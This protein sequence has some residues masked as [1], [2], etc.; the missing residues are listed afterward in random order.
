MRL[1]EMSWGEWE[2][3]RLD[4]LR[5][6]LG[7]NMRANEALGLDF[8]PPGGES[9]R[10]VFERVKGFLA[11]VAATG[12]PTL[13]VTHRGVIR[14]IFAHATGWDM[15]GRPPV[16]LDWNAIHVFKLRADGT[17]AVDHINFKLPLKARGE[18]MP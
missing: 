16:K 6:E 2:G 12:E 14:S 8:T 18:T 13:A 15:L 5:V 17:P 9:P 11:Q 1:I 3:R 10:R 4:E 7:E